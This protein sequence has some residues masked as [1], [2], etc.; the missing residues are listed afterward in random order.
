MA[1]RATKKTPTHKVLS[2]RVTV[3]DADWLDGYAKRRGWD[4][5]ELMRRLIAR[6][7]AGEEIDAAKSGPSLARASVT[8]RPKK[9]ST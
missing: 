9:G 3:E 2:V 5:S 1:A 6:L 7:R 4:R 8:P